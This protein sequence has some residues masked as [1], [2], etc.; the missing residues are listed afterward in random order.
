MRA[1]T[2]RIFLDRFPILDP[3]IK[4]PET[5]HPQIDQVLYIKDF[6]RDENNVREA[7][8]IGLHKIM[9]T[10]V[11]IFSEDMLETYYG[12]IKKKNWN[13]SS[14]EVRRAVDE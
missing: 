3:S 10:N 4:L 7:T 9:S 6:L 11:R 14:S 5:V 13:K 2:A 1:N 12:I 8:I